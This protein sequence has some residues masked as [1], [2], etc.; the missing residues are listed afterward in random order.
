MIRIVFLDPDRRLGMGMGGLRRRRQRTGVCGRQNKAAKQ[1]S[2]RIHE[3]AGK[4][5]QFPAPNIV[6]ITYLYRVLKHLRI[7]PVAVHAR[8]IP[9]LPIGAREFPLLHLLS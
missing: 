2:A 9:S 6:S 5:R 4:R 3:T 7:Q 8:T 1:Q